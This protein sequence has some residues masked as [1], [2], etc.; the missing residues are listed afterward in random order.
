MKRHVQ[1]PG[2]RKWS[3]N[4]LLELQ[5][6]GLSVADEFFSQYGDCIICGCQVSDGGITAGLA[7][8]DGMVLP[9]AAVDTVEVFP[10]YLVKAEEHFQREYAD[11]VVRDIAVRCYAKAVQTRPE[12]GGYIEITE[13]GAD[14]FFDRL[15]A[16]WLKDIVNKLTEL[17]NTDKSLGEAIVLLNQADTAAVSR[18]DALEKKMPS[19]LD[20]VPTVD[21]DGY[22]IGVEVWTVDEYGNKTFWKCHDNT[23]GA[24]VWKRTGEGAGGGGSYGGAVYLTGQTDF[25]KA[26]IIIKEGYLS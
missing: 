4:D 19:Y 10:V 1:Y 11:D 25:S 5:S 12:S 17:K 16:K 2:V 7:S 23:E 9:L 24:A 26:T 6:E 3:G 8:I 20:H 22:G 15:Q 13:G 21:D 18:I 14:T